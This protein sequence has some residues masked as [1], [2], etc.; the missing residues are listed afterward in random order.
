[1]S[2]QPNMTEPQVLPAKPKV[3][4]TPQREVKPAPRRG[5]PW[6]VPGPKK[7]PTPKALKNNVMKEKKRVINTK[8]E[9]KLCKSALTKE[10]FYDMFELSM[11]LVCTLRAE[12]MVLDISKTDR[13]MTPE[14]LKTIGLA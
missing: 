9:L 13:M 8:G 11:E 3:K 5:D 4:P 2:K 10:E 7:N 6:T 1:M 14:E 12:K